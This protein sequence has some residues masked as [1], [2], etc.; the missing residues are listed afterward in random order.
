MHGFFLM[1]ATSGDPNENRWQPHVGSRPQ[2]GNRCYKQTKWYK[3]KK[4][5]CLV[6]SYLAS[7]YL[8]FLIKDEFDELAKPT[9]VVVDHS[10]RVA[11]CFQQRI[12]LNARRSYMKCD[13][14]ASV[15]VAGYVV[16]VVSHVI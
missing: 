5:E 15:R 13:P 16:V 4:E 10:L 1:F 3:I 7:E 6:E 2:V 14:L 8:S 9:A 12:D 11:E